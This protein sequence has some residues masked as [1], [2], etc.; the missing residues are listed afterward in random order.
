MLNSMAITEFNLHVGA[1]K[2]RH[3]FQMS[4]PQYYEY[5]QRLK[6]NKLT[7]RDYAKD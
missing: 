7:I 6:D 4:K 5:V 2:S 3:L 1:P